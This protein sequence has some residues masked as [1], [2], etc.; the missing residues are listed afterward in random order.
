MTD[1]AD[2]TTPPKAPPQPDAAADSMTF[3][4]CSVCRHADEVNSA[5][6]TLLCKKHNMLIN[7]EADEIPDEC[8]DYETKDG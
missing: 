1:P 2:A 4:R 3:Q 6:G 8:A 7:A 5:A